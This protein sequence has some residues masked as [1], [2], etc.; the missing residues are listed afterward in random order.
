MENEIWKPDV[1]MAGPGGSRGF[2]E[3]GALKRF[4]E[5]KNF[6]SNVKVWAG[7]SVGAAIS[8]LIVSGYSIKDIIDICIN[9]NI[10]DDILSIKLDTVAEKLG[11]IKLKTIEDKLISC[12]SSKFGFIPSM[13]QIYILTS[14]ELSFATFNFDKMRPEFLDK[15]TT[16]DLSCVEAAM[17]SMSIPF[18]LQP[19]KYRGDLY[20]DGAIG[21]SYPVSNYDKNGKKVLGMYICSNDELHNFNEKPIKFLYR[22]IQ[23]SMKILRDMEIKYSSENVKHVI[24]KTTFK[25]TTGLTINE[26]GR[27]NMIES[28]YKIADSFL[29]INSDPEK[30]SVNIEENEEILFEN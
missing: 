27:Q 6:L 12:V 15:E 9:I 30:Y 5:E 29:K 14:L 21:A 1:V 20:I 25:D 2:L 7:V 13:K 16:P 11:L 4:F 17:M 26:E 8:L 3:I 23:S 24:L 10:L 18:L 19:R 22:L 28:G